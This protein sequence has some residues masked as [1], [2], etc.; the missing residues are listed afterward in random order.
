MVGDEGKGLLPLRWH[1]NVENVGFMGIS[2]QLK[3]KILEVI[4]QR[5]IYPYQIIKEWIPCHAY[6]LLLRGG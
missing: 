6:K 1:D 4:E 2:E 3:S 5:T